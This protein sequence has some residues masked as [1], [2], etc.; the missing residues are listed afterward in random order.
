[1]VVACR[2]L[3]EEHLKALRASLAAAVEVLNELAVEVLNELA[4]PN[5]AGLL[6]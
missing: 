3:K 2:H 4:V 5:D 1:M 6:H